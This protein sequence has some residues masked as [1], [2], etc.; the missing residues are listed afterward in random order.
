MYDLLLW[1]SFDYA[2]ANSSSTSLFK[3]NILSKV[4]SRFNYV[5]SD[6]IVVWRV[7]IL[8]QESRV[9]KCVLVFCMMCSFAGAIGECAL[10]FNAPERGQ[11]ASSVMMEIPLLITNVV[12]TVLMAIKF[13]YYVREVKRLVGDWRQSTQIERVLTLLL[14]SGTIYCVLWAVRFGLDVGV[15]DASTTYDAYSVVSA[16]YHSIAG[17][18]P[19]LIVFVV[20]MERSAA[21]T[22]AMSTQVSHLYASRNTGVSADFISF[23]KLALL[24]TV[25]N[26]VFLGAQTAVFVAAMVASARHESRSRSIIALVVALLLSSML[27]AI[28]GSIFIVIQFPNRITEGVV[29]L[30][31]GLNVSSQLCIRFNFLASDVIVVWRAWVLWQDCPLTKGALTL[32]MVGSILV[33]IV[34][35]IWEASVRKPIP[36]AYSLMVWVPVLFTNVVA[37]SFVACKYWHYRRGLKDAIGLRRKSTRVERLLALL[38]ESGLAYCFIVLLMLALTVESDFHPDKLN[39]SAINTL[40][41][42]YHIIAEI[43]PTFIAPVGNRSPAK[44]GQ[45]KSDT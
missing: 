3:L 38:L 7:W 16:A 6:T 11:R 25:I 21:S 43:Y 33:V 19:T 32:C 34:D 13:W 22:L 29:Q 44:C 45:V 10:Y 12:T 35:Y 20:A 14:E 37:T 26:F 42:A 24:D 28:L 17:I 40:T 31:R 2:T 30:A 27:D 36:A 41:T 1:P 9:V 18:L 8:W 39:P 15:D 23:C 5:M 4:C